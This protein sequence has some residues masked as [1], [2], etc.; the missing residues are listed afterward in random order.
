MQAKATHK[1]T[2]VELGARCQALVT[3]T[4]DEL[5]EC[6]EA[7]F[8]AVLQELETHQVEL[9]MQNH[10]LRASREA[11]EESQSKYVDL[12][13]FAPTGYVTITEQGLIEELNLTAATLFG[14]ERQWLLGRSL[15]PWIHTADLVVFRN[16]LRKCQTPDER[17]TSRLH[18][19]RR[20]G[21]IIPVD[22]VSTH[23]LHPT[24]GT[25]MIRTTVSDL[26]EQL[27]MEDSLRVAV[28]TLKDEKEMRE[29]FVSAL[30]HD[31]RT[32]LTAVKIAAQLLARGSVRLPELTDQIQVN[33]DRIDKM[34]Q[35]LLD[36]NLI[37]AGEKLCLR[38]A[39]L[40]VVKVARETLESIRGQHGDRFVL[41][42]PD[43]LPGFLHEASLRR[44]IENLANNAVK[45]GS[46]DTPITVT[47]QN[48][49]KQSISICVHNLGNAIPPKE[50]ASLFNQFRRGST[51]D[52][53]LQK[54]WGL[55]LTLVRGLAEAQQGQISVE[56]SPSRGTTF[57]VVL[58]SGLPRMTT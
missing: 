30:T 16:H 8:L 10:E 13:D 28:G 4:G 40:D 26:S 18:I 58:P 39:E 49:H 20:D 17:V 12:Y 7:E 19:R 48:T 44:M 14:V 45:Y 35:D 34:I 50:Q 24:L 9:E 2:K 15:A 3:S 52:K 54:G 47:L 42:A 21:H 29:R 43:S 27:E 55:G 5:E 33:I 53:P 37:Q 6:R 1:M 38:L 25:L 31:L 32:P 56:S 46:S 36:A 23:S 41:I 11:L 57:S 51:A 22:L